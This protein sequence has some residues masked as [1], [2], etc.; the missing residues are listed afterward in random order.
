MRAVLPIAH[1]NGVKIITNMGAANPRAAGE[2]VMAVAKELGISGLKIAVVEGDDV[3]AAL[4]GSDLKM[5]ETGERI[6]DL[7]ER[8]VS[9]NAY[10]GVGGIVEALAR[11]ADVVITGRAADPAL[12]LAPLV[13]EFGWAMDDWERL[14]RGT[15]AG[16]LLECAGQITGGYFADPG[17]KDVTGLA[18]LGFP[19]GE[20]D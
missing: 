11:G 1:R 5:M 7:G 3:T 8:L 9:A 14:G 15:L 13:H 20:I 10:L 2:C 17:V 16:H 6:A 12:F 4:R 19:L 18:R